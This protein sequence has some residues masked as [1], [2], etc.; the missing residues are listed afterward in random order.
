M[1]KKINIE[2]IG[3]LCFLVM[4]YF[5]LTYYQ[6]RL[7]NYDS[8]W[9]IFQ[10]TNYEKMLLGRPAAV[11]NQILPFLAVKLG[12]SLKLV[13]ITFSSSFVFIY[14]SIF[15]L[16]V[17]KM[18]DV[19]SGIAFCITLLLC[20]KLTFF[21]PV[22]EVFIGCAF[23]MLYFSICKN[24]LKNRYFT[25]VSV[26]LVL[27]CYYSHPTT[28]FLIAFSSLYVLIEQ[29]T[30]KSKLWIPLLFTI[31]L[32]TIK[33]ILTP[34][35]GPE[36]AEF[37]EAKN[38]IYH[39]TN[40]FNL[41]PTN[42][43]ISNGFF[44][45]N[46][47][48][49]WVIVT[50]LS[51]ITLLLKKKYLKLFLVIG[52]VFLFMAVTNSVYWKGESS[53]VLEKSVVPLAFFS[54]IPFVFELLP[55][56]K[57][58]KWLLLSILSILFFIKF[59]DIGKNAKKYENRVEYYRNYSDLSKENGIT[60][61]MISKEKFDKSPLIIPWAISIE[62]ILA[63]SLHGKTVTISVARSGADS[64]QF[65]GPQFVGR[66]SNSKLNSNYF[67]LEEEPYSVSE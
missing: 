15:L 23:S 1:Q 65:Y 35:S 6:E 29:K 12:L 66:I 42:Q 67:K 58:K 25:F 40:F 13:F 19:N 52:F 20:V 46:K 9:Y 26:V 48:Q 45:S 61:Y 54:S 22:S 2:L 30:I 62:S 27:L 56:L 21:N 57:D 17:R 8:A 44:A 28:A 36:G 49:L 59:R 5:A 33:V 11:F 18:K 3:H 7:L 51:L 10:I 50:T 60:K 37:F 4:L 31:L 55:V 32:Y 16:I 38:F 14:Y 34:Q 63:S 41:P 64:N 47:Y 53:I 43:L 39:L 24:H